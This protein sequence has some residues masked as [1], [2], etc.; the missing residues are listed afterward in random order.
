MT[1]VYQTE[2]AEA[3]VSSL[4]DEMSSLECRYE[5][6]VSQM[7]HWEEAVEQLTEELQAALDSLRTREDRG[8]WCEEEMERFIVKV[9]SQHKQVGF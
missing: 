8:L 3:E 4:R 9:D 6:K 2:E 5:K 7:E 1:G